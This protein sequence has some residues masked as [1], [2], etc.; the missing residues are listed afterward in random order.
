MVEKKSTTAVCE[1]MALKRWTIVVISIII[2][3]FTVKVQ[4]AT[5]TVHINI[6]TYIKIYDSLKIQRYCE[7][8]YRIL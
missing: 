5:N 7:K 1:V 8:M 3:Y 4:V 2:Y 6:V